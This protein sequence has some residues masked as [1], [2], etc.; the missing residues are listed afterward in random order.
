MVKVCLSY[1]ALVPPYLVPK[2]FYFINPNHCPF[3]ILNIYRQ[4]VFVRAGTSFLIRGFAIFSSLGFEILGGK[5]L[6]DAKF[7]LLYYF[8]GLFFY[9]F[10]FSHWILFSH[11]LFVL[12]WVQVLISLMK[13]LAVTLFIL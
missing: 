10:Q 6:K 9:S 4:S 13:L 7:F 8:V 1:L 11:R 5:G 12:L 2:L 3:S